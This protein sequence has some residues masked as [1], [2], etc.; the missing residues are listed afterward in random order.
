MRA[1][2]V[3]IF[4]LG[5]AT[6]VLVL[7]LSLWFSGGLRISSVMAG[8]T[9]PAAVVP[10]APP[11][12]PPVAPAVSPAPAPPTIPVHLA[13]PIAGVDPEELEDTFNEIHSGHK[14]EAL[15]IPAPKGTPV[16]AVAEGNVVK[17]FDSKAGGI[18][19]YQFDNTRT[20]CY[21]YAHLDRYA[22]G[23]KEN[24]LLRKGDVLGY[25]GSTGNASPDAPHLHFEVSQ[26][27]PEK[28]WWEGTPIDPLPLLK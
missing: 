9:V 11:L 1:R 25:V 7:A 28:K 19:V 10:A 23:L 20:Y 18:T 12:T 15:D 27:G 24:T 2:M 22:A 26:L 17:L 6:G 4:A 5:F 3:G 13:M 8:G 21:Y 14:H 16:M